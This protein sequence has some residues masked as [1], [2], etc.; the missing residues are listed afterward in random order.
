MC[1]VTFASLRVTG[2]CS[3]P[4]ISNFVLE[5]M[6]KLLGSWILF[7]SEEQSIILAGG[8]ITGRYLDLNSLCIIYL[9]VVLSPREMSQS[10]ETL[11]APRSAPYG[12]RGKP[13]AFPQPRFRPW[14]LLLLQSGTPKLSVESLP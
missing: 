1:R 4:V 2:F 6:G 9:L 11:F 14:V 12:F 10:W 5:A 8:S 13:K 7:S 3:L